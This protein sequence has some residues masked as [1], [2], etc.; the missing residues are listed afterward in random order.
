MKKLI[1]LLSLA[2]SVS[3]MAASDFSCGGTEPFWDLT[4]KGDTVTYNAV[5]S[6]DSIKTEQVTSRVNAAGTQE[7]YA[8]IVKTETTSSTILAG[9]CSD[10]M[11]DTVYSHNIILT[12]G[13]QVLVGCCNQIK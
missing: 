11:S 12:T 13:D 6:D 4:I 7:D 2:M 8:V 1:I 9:E 5:M 10:G 3:A